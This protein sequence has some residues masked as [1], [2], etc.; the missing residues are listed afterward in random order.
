MI[1]V[2]NTGAGSGDGRQWHTD[3]PWSPGANTCICG[4]PPRMIRAGCGAEANR[5]VQGPTSRPLASPWG[6]YQRCTLPAGGEA[7]AG[8]SGRNSRTS[9]Q[10][11][12]WAGHTMNTGGV[13]AS[14][15]G[16]LSPKA[17]AQGHGP[18]PHSPPPPPRWYATAGRGRRKGACIV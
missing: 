9:P 13:P 6:N 1:R 16:A 4:P 5:S 15:P 8:I 10:P 3:S 18:P 11:T 12:S 7:P 14:P 2:S 17:D